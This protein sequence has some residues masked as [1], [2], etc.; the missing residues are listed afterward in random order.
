MYD[1]TGKSALSVAASDDIVYALNSER[2][3]YSAGKGLTNAINK[4][5]DTG[6][7]INVVNR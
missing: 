7:D 1:N 2:L 4:I 6:V 5:L 3:I